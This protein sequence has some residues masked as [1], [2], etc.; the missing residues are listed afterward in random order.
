MTSPMAKCLRGCCSTP[1]L[2]CE[3]YKTKPR[4]FVAFFFT[5]VLVG[6]VVKVLAVWQVQVLGSVGHFLSGNLNENENIHLNTKW[7]GPKLL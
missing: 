1:Y 7:K 2:F 5:R 4:G 6:A 3:R